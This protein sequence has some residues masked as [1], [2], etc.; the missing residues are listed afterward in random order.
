MNKRMSINKEDIDNFLEKYKDDLEHWERWAEIDPKICKKRYYL[1][2]SLKEK[3]KKPDDPKNDETWGDLYKHAKEKLNNFISV[4]DVND[5][6]PASDMYIDDVVHIVDGKYPVIPR[7][8]VMWCN[9]GDTIIYVKG[10]K[11][12]E[13]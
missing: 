7:G 11:N 3:A 4:D 9:N 13:E 12:E 1:S 8:I 5:W 10:G 6:R 2:Y